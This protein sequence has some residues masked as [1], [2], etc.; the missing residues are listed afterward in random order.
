MVAL[1]RPVIKYFG[2]KWR[3]ARY[4]PFPIY[5]TIV[6]ACAGGAAYACHYPERNI[7]LVDIDPD[8]IEMWQWL[9]AAQPKDVLALPVD[10]LKP[11]QDLR[12]LDIHPAAQKLIGRWQR[13]GRNDCMTV[14]KWHNANSGFWSRSTRAAIAENVKRIKHWKAF[15]ASYADI[16]DRKDVTTFVDSPYQFVKGYKHEKI[17]FPHLG[18][19]CRRRSGQVI[20]CEQAGANWLD[21]KDFR[22]N[23]SGR[24]CEGGTRQK[25]KEVIW[26]N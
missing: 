12:K 26:T 2:S 6:E 1:T 19:W 11:G 25:S 21:F 16:P 3:L 17:D 18:N 22:E 5:N 24:T 14:S 7:I 10:E 9:I 8:V 13:V 23:T 4:Y 20:V 15:C